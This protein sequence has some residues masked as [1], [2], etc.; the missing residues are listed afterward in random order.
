PGTGDL[1]AAGNN[2]TITGAGQATTI[3]QQ[4]QPNDRVL[5]VNQNLTAAFNFIMSGV[6]ITGGRET[7]AVGGGGMVSGGAN[8]LTTV[9]ASTFSNNQETGASGPGGGGV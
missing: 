5:C 2:T 8:N 1:D 4:T 7:F 6:T 3:I 9:S